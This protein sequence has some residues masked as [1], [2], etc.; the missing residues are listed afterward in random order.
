MAAVELRRTQLDW[1]LGPAEAALLI[2]GDQLPFAL[3]GA[4]AG[5]GAIIGSE[6]VRVA[7]A[8]DDPFALLDDTP[9]VD[10][11]ARD[12]VGGGWFGWLG[13]GLRHRVEHVD[14]GPPRPRPLPGFQLG[15]YDHLLRL[16]AQGRWWFEAL[17]TAGRAPALDARLEEL[18]SRRGE[19]QPFSSGPWSAVPSPAGHQTAVAAT[20]ERI[21]A[22]DLFQANVCMRLQARLQGDPLDLFAAGVRALSP[23]RAAYVGGPGATVASLSPEL[24]LERRGSHVRTAPIKGTRPASD[25]P[26]WLE[27]SAKDRAENTMIVDLMRNDLGR[28]CRPGSV[29]VTALAQA[30]PHAGVWHLV[31]EVTGQLRPGAGDGDLLR[32]CFPPGSVTGAPKIAAQNA[33]AEVES[34]G[35]EAYTGAIGF[36]SPVAGLELS[37]AIRTFEFS[38][39][40]V[41]LGVGGGVVADSEPAAEARECAVKAKPLLAAI[42]AEPVLGKF[43]SDSEPNLPRMA[44]RGPQPIPRPDPGAGVFTTLAVRD[45]AAQEA[46][47]HL[48]RLGASAREL[49]G[50]ALPG[51]LAERVEHAAAAHDGPGRMRIEVIPGTSEPTLTV[52]GPDPTRPPVALASVTQPGGIGAHKWIDR[53]LLDALAEQV[54]PALPLLV[55]L[56]G[57]VLESWGANVF[58]RLPDGALVT[59]PLD[60]RILPG[61]TRARLLDRDPGAREQRLTLEQLRASR[62]LYVTGSLGGVEPVVALDG[63]QVAANAPDASSASTSVPRPTR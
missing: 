63:A 9:A 10:A 58:A 13:Y 23:D 2:R 12:G 42:G 55:D 4:W 61:V 20:R 48:A 40:H 50:V 44:R 18:R 28:V 59:P 54:A 6:P 7:A 60:G 26:A 38:G 3:V 5:G 14:P 31:S 25:D 56:D 15:F 29:E 37:V 21:H 34:S 57:W 32:A 19:P 39:E 49:Y 33:I 27:S 24:F 51:D 46:P 16:D 22:G 11:Q 62:E 35:R 17:W 53:R 8:G 45:G 1:T 30:R 47:A 41:W 43:G 36:A 52:T